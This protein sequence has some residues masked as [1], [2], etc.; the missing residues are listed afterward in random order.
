MLKTYYEKSKLKYKLII[1]FKKLLF[2]KSKQFRHEFST[3]SSQTQCANTLIESNILI[4]AIMH[5]V[6]IIFIQQNFSDSHEAFHDRFI[7]VSHLNF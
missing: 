2:V 4:N 7:N 3:H 5:L 6:Q 1:K